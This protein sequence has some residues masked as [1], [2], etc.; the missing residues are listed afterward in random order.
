MSIGQLYR[1]TRGDGLSRPCA[2]STAR[3]AAVSERIGD[4]ELDDGGEAHVA[5]DVVETLRAAEDAAEA[6]H[7]AGALRDDAEVGAEAPAALR[8]EVGVA[9][10]DVGDG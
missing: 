8:R 2:C 6:D 9:D 5:D 3:Q 4:A 10:P 7:V 1:E